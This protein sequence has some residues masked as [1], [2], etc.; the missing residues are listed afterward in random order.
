MR[1]RMKELRSSK[2][3]PLFIV[4]LVFLLALFLRAYFA[5]DLSASNGWLMS[6]GSDSYYYHRLMD[7]AA[8]TGEHVYMDPMLNYPDGARN[9]RPPFFTFSVAAPA[10]LFEGAFSTLADSLGFFFIM[11][12]AIW[13][14]LTVIPV[15]LI[16]KEIFSRRAGYVA[17]LFLAIM[18]S[19]VE[20]SVATLCDHDSFALFFIVLTVYFLMKAMKAT[21]ASKWVENWLSPRSIFRGLGIFASKSQKGILYSLLTGLSFAAIAMAWV[22]F[23]YIEVI[24][25][26]FFLI[27]V[28]VNKFK[29]ID[30]TS[31]TLIFFI[32]FGFGFLITYPVYHQM[33][34]WNLDVPFYLF[35]AAI[36]VGVLF[37]ATRELPWLMTLP[38]LGA[39]LAI[40]LVVVTVVSPALGEAIFSG[41]GYFGGSKLYETI[42]EARAPVFSQLA[43]SFGAVTFYLSFVG[44]ILMLAKIPKRVAGDFLLISI[45]M[46]VAIFMAT[47]AGR[48]MFNAAPAFAIASAWITVMIVD[49]LD[50]K[51]VGKLISGSSGS[52]FQV[53]RKSVKIRHVVGALFVVFLLIV[54]NAWFSLDAGIPMENKRAYDNSIYNTFP[55]FMRPNASEYQQAGNMWYFGSF[56]YSLPLPRTYF[57][58]MWRWLAQQDADILPE[59]ARPAYVS[60]WDYGFEAIDAGGHPAVAD[61]FQQGY[62]IGGDIL[63]APSESVAVG[64]MI[65]RLLV[66][67]VSQ[68]VIPPLISS[69]LLSSGIDPLL[70]KDVIANSSKYKSVVM[71]YP[72]IY[73]SATSDITNL[74]IM[75]RYLGVLFAD[76]GLEKEVALYKSL[77]DITGYS[78]GYIGVDA[79]LLPVSAQNVGV[80]YAPVKL[81]DRTID[82]DGN[83]SDYYAVV[84][85]DSNGV[86]YSLSELSSLPPTTVITGYKLTY[87]DAFF[88][89]ILYRTYAG[90][91]PKD[92][93]KTNDGLPGYSGSVQS[94][95]PMPAWNMNHFMLA[96]RTAYYNPASDG[97]GEW[98]AISFEDAFDVQS[99]ID[100]GT[101]EGIVDASP[102]SAYQAGTVLIKYYDGAV[103]SGKITTLAGDPAPAI[104]AT[105]H[106]KYGIPHQTVLSDANGT[107]SLILPPGEDRIFFSTGKLDP[108][109][110]I[111]ENNIDTFVLNVTADMAARKNA[112]TDGDGRYDWQV[113]HDTNIQTG[114]LS[115]HV[116]WDVDKDRNYTEGIDILIKNSTLVA[117]NTKAYGISYEIDAGNGSY[118]AALTSGSYAIDTTVN[119]ITTLGEYSTDI[120]PGSRIVSRVARTLTSINGTVMYEDGTPASGARVSIKADYYYLYP[121]YAIDYTDEN[122]TYS[123]N[124]V[125]PGSYTLSASMGDFF[126]SL[127]KSVLTT[128]PVTG[129]KGVT[130]E[131]LYRSSN[132]TLRLAGTLDIMVLGQEGNPFKNAT[133]LISDSFYPSTSTIAFADDTGKASVKLPEGLYSL[134]VSSPTEIGI[135]VGDAGAQVKRYETS[136][137]TI[138]VGSS[139]RVSGIIVNGVQGA[140]A[141]VTGAA[142]V[143]SKGP[144]VYISAANTE[145]FYSLNLPAGDYDALF[146]G[147]TQ[148]ITTKASVSSSDKVF[149]A[150]I[151]NY[152]DIGGDVWHDRNG[153]GVRQSHESIGYSAISILL[154][155]GVTLR[156][157]SNI[158][159]SFGIGVPMDTT[160]TLFVEAVGYT[161]SSPINITTGT[162]PVSLNIKLELSTVSISSKLIVDGKALTNVPVEFLNATRYAKFTSDQN[163]E[164]HG[165]MLPGVYSVRVLTPV[166]PGSATYYYVDKM[167]VVYVGTDISSLEIEVEKRIKV[168]GTIFGAPASRSIRVQ[169]E[170]P[171]FT[172][173]D[174]VGTYTTYLKE[175]SY[176]C[177]AHDSDSKD[178]A[179]IFEFDL[180]VFSNIVDITLVTAY[181]IS[182]NVN[183]GQRFANITLLQI[184]FGASGSIISTVVQPGQPY[185]AVLPAGIYSLHFEMLL[186]EDLQRSQRY[187]KMTNDTTI[188]VASDES[189]SPAMQYGLDN[190]TLNVTIVD[191]KGDP[192]MTEVRFVSMNELSRAESY[193]TDLNGEIRSSIHPGAYT[194]YVADSKTGLSYFNF[195]LIRYRQPVDLRLVLT[196]GHLLEVAATADNSTDLISIK[197]AI[198]NIENDAAI[199]SVTR[200]GSNAVSMVVPSGKYSVV[201]DGRRHEN[202]MTIG[203]SSTL[204]TEVMTTD[205][206]LNAQLSRTNTYSFDASWDSDQEATISLGE[207]VN[208]IIRIENTGNAKDTYNLGGSGS[209]FTFDFQEAPVQLDFGNANTS[210]YA[211]V[212][213]TANADASVNHGDLNINIASA[214]N[215]SVTKSVKVI[216]KVAPEYLA[217]ISYNESGSNSG[218]VFFTD[219]K[220]K[221]AGNIIDNYTL[222]IMNAN[223][224]QLNGWSAT[225]N[226]TSS[227]TD[228]LFRVGPG[229]TAI[230]NITLTAIRAM[231]KSNVSVAVEVRSIS[232]ALSLVTM[233]TPAIP[234]LSF[235]LDEGQVQG[236]NIYTHDVF[237]ERENENLVL[238]AVMIS[239]L[240]AVF[241]I[242]KIKF[243]RFLR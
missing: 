166:T 158:T 190:S 231:P 135:L 218:M 61:N 169:F 19:H 145:G 111:G 149:N 150:N 60:W 12:T 220:V 11:S 234:D 30:S 22:G 46:A 159:G 50:F 148:M 24:L 194:I 213:I 1:L 47:S 173:L 202:G 212:T 156:T 207:S 57:P 236:N 196:Q 168:D 115:G 32:A 129:P 186:F 52:F 170:G 122:G 208:Y 124:Q 177:Y 178:S 34:L 130:D 25:L 65:S 155:D 172:L 164:I 91:S 108:Q 79:R 20:R 98:H 176:V 237:Q 8:Q 162:S 62:Q 105:V 38:L 144:V 23:A 219:L 112:D 69:A 121:V 187:L 96:Y 97:S 41:Q 75:W 151:R 153:D 29:G 163:G 125:L 28:L 56:S 36:I 106:D 242:R 152:V 142:A 86:D 222:T 127:P 4:L 85:T 55:D 48:F 6:G 89:T 136:S 104:R 49:K 203:Y 198:M 137:V 160:M 10:V 67:Q 118:E 232:S 58:A 84:A 74:N 201:V 44:L 131:P 192:V 211:T 184:L 102:R 120:T 200:L 161:A 123:F 116:F 235:W 210:T 117:T 243:G 95:P 240:A 53:L 193:F 21:E 146:L 68:P 226:G 188:F 64:L 171:T 80:F 3:M 154:P 94:I 229:D 134:I 26:A 78:I 70:V 110:L 209:G 7:H 206:V 175:G 221:N 227:L 99:K 16:A 83:P 143:F 167:L 92:V 147:G 31:A 66:G 225:I 90:F 216:I 82:A 185:S 138:R 233:V 39:F 2:F 205:V 174:A 180:T 18:P 9:P 141:A 109:S 63:L 189:F 73:G 42:A 100:A 88:D 76:L 140:T 59:N 17:A 238:M 199:K 228:N 15:Y 33:N 51:T 37:S 239:M 81:T 5:Y 107:Y 54:P 215:S 197:L 35:G 72:N 77:R 165:Q 128:K 179:A 45:W 13:G 14:A 133:I 40:S 71:T 132:I 119:G 191:E 126:A 204:R 183:I 157:R 139:T 27:Q 195:I 101:M 217:V 114:I 182:G 87:T 113:T 241:I 223:E 230:A 214:G 224:L 181:E 103:L 93:G 43:V